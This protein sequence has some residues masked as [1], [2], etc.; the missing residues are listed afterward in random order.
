MAVRSVSNAIAIIRHLAVAEPQGVNAVARAVGLSPSSCFNI[1]K[2]LVAER[3]V[4][5][6]P[7]TK[8]YALEALPARMFAG[9][10][11]MT[12]WHEWLRGRLGR[13]ANAHFLSCGLWQVRA[14]RVI[15]MEVVDS[16]DPTRVYLSVG[17]RLPAHI[18]AMGRCVAAHEG[19]SRA[20]VA[21]IVTGLRWQSAPSVAAFWQD[22]QRV[23]ERGW[24]ADRSN[25]IRG[26][27]SVAAPICDAEGT[28]RY[29][30]TGTAFA[31]QHDAEA[32]VLIGEEMAKVAAEAG[33]RRTELL[34]A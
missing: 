34:A 19:L 2:T 27:T 7:Q 30:I 12:A 13:V 9:A 18:G 11:D 16:P 31:G 4:A 28:V 1:L 8:K 14:G 23:R 3:V 15:L 21:D 29:C 26:L 33:R 25:Y 10:P 17:Q 20:E 32:L 24:A 6:D 22:M 5:F